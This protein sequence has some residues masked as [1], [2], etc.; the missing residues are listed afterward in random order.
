[1]SINLSEMNHSQTEQLRRY[2]RCLKEFEALDFHDNYVDQ[3]KQE[4]NQLKAKIEG[5]NDK[6]C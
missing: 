3:I 5:Q 1:M 4:Y 6:Q 2:R